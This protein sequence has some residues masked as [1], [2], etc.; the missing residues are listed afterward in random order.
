MAKITSGVS[1]K[2]RQTVQSLMYG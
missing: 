2:Q 1:C